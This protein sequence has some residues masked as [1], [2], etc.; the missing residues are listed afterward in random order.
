MRAAV[1]FALGLLPATVVAAAP[2][3]PYRAFVVSDEAEI[4]SGPGDHY[5]AVLAV[6]RGELIEVHRH[7]P[8]GWCAIRPP[9][10]SF[11]W[12]AAEFIEPGVGGLATITG[13]QVVARTGSAESEIRDVIQVRLDLGEQV[14]LLEPEPKPFGVDGRLWYKIA[15]PA[16]EFR[17]ISAK[18]IDRR[19]P[20]PRPGD[21]SAA[22][23]SNATAD[24]KWRKPDEPPSAALPSSSSADPSDA[25]LAAER[26]R[27]ELEALDIE[28]SSRVIREPDSWNL[29]ALSA[30]VEALL[31][32]GET[33]EQRG[34]ARLLLNKIAR[35]EEIQRQYVESARA[36]ARR[37]VA[38]R[39]S[40][41]PT[42]DNT[43]Q[44]AGDAAADRRF[45][46]A[47]RLIEVTSA[48]LGAPR[49]AL[50]DEKG[51]VR[52][53]VVPAPG[54]SLRS[55]LGREIGVTGSLGYL[56]DRNARLVTASRV[57]ELGDATTL[58]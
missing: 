11:S 58:R 28:L 40:V 12:V 29:D 42:S 46:G 33:S 19:P 9:R 21:E 44:P 55:Y 24:S 22:K 13:D 49:Y 1:M 5:Y 16:G 52:Y 34:Q 30:Q 14:E 20:R 39:S 53:Y 54:V 51:D 3:F 36:G 56:Y 2:E 57:T 26:F 45:D 31:A 38:L 35:F 25:E 43:R 47:G 10:G 7:D 41:E 32:R 27:L 37:E 6:P 8:N 23:P 4:R 17:W 15:P 50:V 18:H 48:K